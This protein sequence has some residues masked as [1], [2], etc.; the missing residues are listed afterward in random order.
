MHLLK[1]YEKRRTNEC[2]KKNAYNNNMSQVNVDKQYL[3]II[4]LFI[5]FALVN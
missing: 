2:E 4:S 3:H 5:F 1:S